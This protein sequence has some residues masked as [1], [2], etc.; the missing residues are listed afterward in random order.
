MKNY[1]EKEIIYII[2]QKDPDGNWNKL[3]KSQE[4]WFYTKSEALEWLKIQ[5]DWL[6]VFLAV[7]EVEITIDNV[8]KVFDGKNLNIQLYNKMKTGNKINK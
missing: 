2:S 1:I 5:P 6:Q 8:N 3:V 4:R 7:F